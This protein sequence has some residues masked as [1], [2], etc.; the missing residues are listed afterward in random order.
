MSEFP[1]NIHLDSAMNWFGF[2]AQRSKVKVA[3]TRVSHYLSWPERFSVFSTCQHLNLSMMKRIVLYICSSFGS[4]GVMNSSTQ[5]PIV[6]SLSSSLSLSFSLAHSPFPSSFPWVNIS[7]SQITS[8]EL[9]WPWS[10]QTLPDK[11]ITII[12]V[13]L[14][15]VFMHWKYLMHHSPFNASAVFVWCPSRTGQQLS[16]KQRFFN[17]C[18][19]LNSIRNK[20]LVYFSDA[21]AEPHLAPRTTMAAAI[22][23]S[24]TRVA[25]GVTRLCMTKY[26]A[27][28][29][30]CLTPGAWAGFDPEFM[31]QVIYCTVSVPLGLQVLLKLC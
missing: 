29:A 3:V 17:G 30:E 6:Q 2:G 14:Q 22:A 19:A 15:Y 23:N 10:Q 27:V 16:L 1:T 24:G 13:C 7:S 9:Y 12:T 25:D 31:S 18:N 26:L 28:S 8:A 21:S 11:L 4:V 20:Q 5:L